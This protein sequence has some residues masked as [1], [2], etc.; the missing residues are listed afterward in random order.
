MRIFISQF[1]VKFPSDK[2][3]ILKNFYKIQNNNI[4]NKYNWEFQI[5]IKIN[6]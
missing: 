3:V 5:E 1:N 4:F 6:K 2:N